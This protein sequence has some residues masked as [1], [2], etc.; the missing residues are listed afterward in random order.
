MVNKT[1]K[2][3]FQIKNKTLFKFIYSHF[4][5]RNKI[6]TDEISQN[7]AAKYVFN[8]KY[9]CRKPRTFNEYLGWLK[10]NYTNDLWK[11]CT[12][13]LGAKQ[14]LNEI[15]L[16]NYV[17][18]TLAVYRDSSEINLCDLPDK[19]VLKTNHDSGSVYLCNKN[20]TDFKT[21]FSK[22]DA[23]LKRRYNSNGEWTYFDIQ[24]VIFAEEIL[25]PTGGTDLIDYKF[26]VY[27]GKF[28]WGFTGQNRNTDCRF[29]VFEKKFE[30]Q[31][32]DYIYP[33]PNKN[34]FPIKP[35]HFNEMV[36]IAEEI[37][38][39]FWFVRVDLY[40]TNK[41]IMVGELTFFSQ[42]GLGPFTSKKYDLKYGKLFENTTI[43]LLLNSKNY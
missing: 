24:P 13:K 28:R 11:K 35:I 18:K 16:S 14:F 22:L 10:F 33:R 20:N 21:V 17:P 26:F 29:I 36:R 40:E 7:Q 9:D 23:S 4:F 39:Y 38:K 2:L 8:Y 37:G 42:S 5:K 12:D 31:D 34:H 1:S 15:G 6:I 19:F 3:L 41:G 25:E 27:N 30:I 32:V 43:S